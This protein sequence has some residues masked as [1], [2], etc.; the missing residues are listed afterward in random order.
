MALNQ[1]FFTPRN[2]TTSPTL[3]QVLANLNALPAGTYLIKAILY[4]TGTAPVDGVDDSNLV[5][6]VDGALTAGRFFY[7]AAGGLFTAYFEA[8]TVGLAFAGNVALVAAAAG[9]VGT[10][11]NNALIAVPV[12]SSF[13]VPTI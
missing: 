13:S 8:V 3:L 9:T 11:Y 5:L 7:P 6:Q 1:Q 2:R 10:I 4:M 12:V